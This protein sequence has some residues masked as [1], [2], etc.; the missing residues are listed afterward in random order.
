MANMAASERARSLSKC[1]RVRVVSG[2]EL[3]ILHIGK[4]TSKMENISWASFACV[5]RL[6]KSS[7]SVISL[8]V[9]CS[10]EL[11]FFSAHSAHSAFLVHNGTFSS[12]FVFHQRAIQCKVWAS[13]TNNIYSNVQRSENS[14]KVEKRKRR[15]KEGKKTVARESIS[16]ALTMPVLRR[17]NLLLPFAVVFA[18]VTDVVAV[19]RIAWNK[20]GKCQQ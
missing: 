20:N 7:S 11:F 19:V 1:V 4:L 8:C 6:Q 13:E 15:T 5:A 18:F 2:T 14:R 3:S 12:F 10:T 17:H 16:S 9:M